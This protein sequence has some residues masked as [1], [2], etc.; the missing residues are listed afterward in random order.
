M[1][2]AEAFVALL[3]GVNVGR[4][5]RLPMAD[6]RKVLSGLGYGGVRT[7]LNS[8]NAVFESTGRSAS[9]HATRIRAALLETLG[10]DVP[11]VVKSAGDL[12]AIEAENRLAAVATNPSRLLVAFTG[13]AKGH[14][15]LAALAP[16]A[17]APE[18]FLMGKHAMYLWVPDGIL[19]SP[20][21]EAL[22]GKLG[23]SATTRNWAT[24]T[25]ISALV[26]KETIHER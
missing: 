5:K 20:A 6:F 22:L 10:L 11:V 18:K 24:V 23:K 8:G 14:R 13:D 25:K 7:L 15:D 16:L 19:Q 1:P 4:A 9:T 26:R 21:A 3:R 17:K 2:A 12:A